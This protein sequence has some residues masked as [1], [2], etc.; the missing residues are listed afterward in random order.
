MEGLG[1]ISCIDNSVL[2][3]VCLARIC[4]YMKVPFHPNRLYNGTLHYDGSS[5]YDAKR[6]YRLGNSLRM[7]YRVTTVEEG[8]GDMAI[9]TR[10]NVQYYDGKMRY[11][12]TTGYN[13]MIRKDVI[14]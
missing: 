13:A 3:H 6:R 2:N 1:M 5:S 11:D 12:G 10:R 4:L 9:E 7:R 8:I 14:E